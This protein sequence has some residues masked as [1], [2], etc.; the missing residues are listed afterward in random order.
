MISNDR[1]GE[2]PPFLA[3]SPIRDP[4]RL[5][6]LYATFRQGLLDYLDQG[7]PGTVLMPDF[8]PQGVH[9]PYLRAGWRI[10]FYPSAI[11]M[12]LDLKTLSRRLEA[13]RPRHVVYI[14]YFGAYLQE[15]LE[16]LRSILPAE[17]TLLEDFGHTLPQDDLKP[18]GGLAAYSFTKML[19]VPEGGLLWFRDR[20]AMRPCRYGQDGELSL[21]LRRR[22]E[23]RASLE[24]FFAR[25]SAP[26]AVESLVRRLLRRRTDY[27]GFLQERYPEIRARIGPRSREILA[28]VDLARVAERRREIARLY[29]EGIVPRLK[30]P[31]ADE[32]LLRQPL[33]GYPVQVDDRRAF[34][35]HLRGHGVRGSALVDH[36]WFQEE[37]P[38]HALRDRHYLLPANHYLGDDDIRRVIA[39]ANQF[40]ARR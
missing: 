24:A 19:G 31:V 3:P 39:A 22:L 29:V 17:T 2:R 12:A 9:D 4:G 11:S 30:L 26:A 28:R 38:P 32:A 36:W 33:Y 1:A 8:V 16:I 25:R 27:Y 20:T 40:V 18:Q 37:R 7:T 23:R 15:N 21:D 6:Y 5:Q 14:H 13:E 35:L 34:H 10:V